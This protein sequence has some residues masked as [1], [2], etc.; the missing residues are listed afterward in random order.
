[1][2]TASVVTLGKSQ[3]VSAMNVK[4]TLLPAQK[5]VYDRLPIFSVSIR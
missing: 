1:M 3:S 4:V 5:T 2:M